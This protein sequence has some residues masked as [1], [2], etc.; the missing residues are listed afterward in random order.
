MTR[1]YNN[2]HHVCAK[3]KDG[4]TNN[5][6]SLGARRQKSLYRK[7]QN[8]PRSPLSREENRTFLIRTLNFE[9]KY[10]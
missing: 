3:T 5:L 2:L 1:F 4:K 7:S 6:K 9:S 10:I 8:H